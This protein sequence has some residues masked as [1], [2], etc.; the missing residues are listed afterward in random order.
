MSLN[1]L[2]AICLLIR[3]PLFIRIWTFS[4]QAVTDP[5]ENIETIEPIELIEPFEPIEPI[6][7]IVPILPSEPI[8]PIVTD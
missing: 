2:A 5:N 3:K 6:E 8:E 1:F 7:P 4:F